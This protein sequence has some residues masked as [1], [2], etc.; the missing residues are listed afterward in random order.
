MIDS[1][2]YTALYISQLILTRGAF[3]GI[4]DMNAS[5]IVDDQAIA[6]LMKDHYFQ[7]LTIN[8]SLEN[9]MPMELFIDEIGISQT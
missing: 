2:R 7:K 3:W 8:S 5:D 9:I 6:Q 4:N 1:S